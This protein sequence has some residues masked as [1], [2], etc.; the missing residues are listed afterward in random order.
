MTKGKQGKAKEGGPTFEEAIDRL[1]G[2]VDRLEKGDV[3]LE[4]ALRLFE[5]GVGLSR[6]CTARLEE[7]QQRLE[8]LGKGSDGRPEAKPFALE[9]KGGVDDVDN[10]DDVDDLDDDEDMKG[11]PSLF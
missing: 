8:L 6:L 1:Q 9:G 11:T 10:E 2:I 3:P 7:A 4:E 5:E